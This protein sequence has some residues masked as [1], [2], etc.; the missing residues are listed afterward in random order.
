MSPYAGL[1]LM[2]LAGIG[3]LI[4]MLLISSFIG[5]KNPTV[6]K[7]IPFECGA[8]VTES[9][10]EKRFNVRFYLVTM[11]FILFDV[12]V[13]L[14]YPW[15]VNVVELGWHGYFAVLSFVG[16]LSVGLLYILKKG[17]LDWNKDE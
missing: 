13:I 4:F 8:Y 6:T 15:A 1:L 11:V 9:V 14:T 17:V 7:Q 10:T 12:E 5:P 3:F 16:V 2:M